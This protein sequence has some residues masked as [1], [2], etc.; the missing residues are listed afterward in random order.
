MAHDLERLS[1]QFRREVDEIV[2]AQTLR[3]EGRGPR[4]KGLCR[5]GLF[6]WHIRLRYALLFDR[7]DGLAGHAVEYEC[8]AALRNLRDGWNP[9]AF[10]GDIDEHGRRGQI[11]VPDVVVQSLEMPH[12]LSSGS[13][14]T[15]ETVR[16][17]IVAVTVTAIE[18]AGRCFERQIH[19]AA[20]CICGESG[21]H[22]SVAGV[23]PAIVLPCLVPEFGRLRD[24]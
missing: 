18:I 10:D 8:K 15:D 3:L 16:E 6:A 24:G 20:L 2:I 7:P 4:G 21:P 1:L 9:A 23:A 19:V 5:S 14:E 11:V 12:T 22:A 17:E 13:V